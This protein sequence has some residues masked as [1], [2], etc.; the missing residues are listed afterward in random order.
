MERR[1]VRLLYLCSDFGIDPAG[2]K[3]ASIHVRSVTRA[4]CEIGHDVRILSPKGGC[5]PDHPAQPIL[6]V[7]G[8]PAESMGKLLKKWLVDHGLTDAPAR[9]LRPLIYNAWVGEPAL[10]ALRENPPEA[11]LERLSLFSHVGIDLSEALDVPLVV[12]MNAPLADEAEAYRALQLRPLAR[13]IEGRVLR[14]ADG[15][16]VVSQALAKRLVEAGVRPERVHVVPNGADPS[17][18]TG[19]PPRESCRARWEL[20]GAFVV[21]FVGSLKP[22]HGVDVLLRAFER[23]HRD[24]PRAR[25]LIVGEGPWAPSL[26]GLAI[27]LGLG[28][29]VTFTGALPHAEIPRVLGALDVAVAPFLQV[30]DFYFSP[31]KM[32][33]Y[34]AAGLCVVGSRLGQIAGVVQDGVNGLLCEPDDPE[35]LY[36]TLRRAQGDAALR[37]RLGSAARESIRAGYTWTHTA[38]RLTRVIEDAIAAQR[39]KREAAA[40]L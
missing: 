25:L 32:F 23:L 17:F 16:V 36:R 4:M 2:T 15:V 34:M 28:D 35:S 12:E 1:A 13:E 27:D 26:R 40:I 20:D 9:E 24:D 7:G 8:G 5:I 10:A 37:R 14:R 29:R 6:G 38:R 33:E 39:T 31:I 30:H 22:W 21:G 3:G 18:F 11:I 19:I